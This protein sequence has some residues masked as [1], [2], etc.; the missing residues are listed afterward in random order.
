MLR[1][2]RTAPS[3]AQSTGIKVVVFEIIEEVT[4][5]VPQRVEA[6]PKNVSDET[7]S[8]RRAE[9]GKTMA[10]IGLCCSLTGIASPVKKV[11][12]N[13]AAGSI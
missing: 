13:R 7:T 6:W 2:P 8:A 10:I 1:H 9:E 5:Q 4:F 3:L 12:R 11:T